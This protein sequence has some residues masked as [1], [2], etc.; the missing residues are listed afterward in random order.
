MQLKLIHYLIMIVFNL[1]EL[2]FNIHTTKN[3]HINFDNLLENY[4]FDMATENIYKYF[5]INTS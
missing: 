4:M 2:Y 5:I 1:I 3:K